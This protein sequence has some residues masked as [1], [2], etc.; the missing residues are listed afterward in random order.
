[1]ALADSGNSGGAGGGG[2]TYGAG[3][4]S[5]TTSTTGKQRLKNI[6]TARENLANATQGGGMPTAM[7]TQ[8]DS[9]GRPLGG[10]SMG[11]F[12]VVQQKPANP[13]N[14]NLWM[15]SQSPIAFMDYSDATNMYY[16]WDTKTRNKF[17]SQLNLAG[18]DTTQ[19]RDADVAKLWAG[20][21]G[22]AAQ[23]QVAGKHISPWD[24]LGKDIAQRSTA[25]STPRTVSAT[26]QTYNISTAEDAAA[27]FQGAAQTLLGRDPTKAE[28][29][30]FKTIL[31]K[32]EQA[33]PATTTTTSTYVGQDMTGQTSKTEGGVSAAAQ[34]Y[35]AQEEA[36]K[37]PEYGAYQAATNGMSW[38]M[39]M[40]G[41]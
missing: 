5:D 24:V 32:Y 11:S 18:Y 29:A 1:M 20:Y 10:G 34:Q 7:G 41:G 14:P 30:K 17:M 33:H 15:G 2:G 35:I 36:K 28:Q 22:V 4:P 3:G 23:Y 8:T 37:D 27:L 12:P 26:Q 6:D 40:L 25:A 13:K 21:V 9:M 19:M 31:N 39:E 16:L 38:L